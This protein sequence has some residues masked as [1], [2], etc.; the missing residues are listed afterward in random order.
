MFN[1]FVA[2][3]EEHKTGLI[4]SI[5][6]ALLYVFPIILAGQYYV[7]DMSRVINGGGWDHDGRFVATYLMQ[8][9]SFGSVI[10]SSFPY[11]TMISAVLLA[12]AGYSL[13][14]IFGIEEGKKIKISSL[15][16]ITSP[17][18]LE[19]LYY[20]YDSIIMALAVLLAI[21]PFYF[22]SK[23]RSFLIIS[24]ICLYLSF[25]L[26]QTAV[27]VYFAMMLLYILVCSTKNELNFKRLFNLSFLALVSF[28]IA[29]A[30]YKYSLSLLEIKEAARGKLMILESNFLDLF[31]DRVVIVYR[32]LV[33]DLWSTN[34]KYS[35]L[36][37][38]CVSIIGFIASFFV[39]RNI[40]FVLLALSVGLLIFVLIGMP[41]LVIKEPWWTARTFLVYP[42]L[43]YFIVIFHR[44]FR[45]QSLS[46][47]SIV[48]LVCFSFL[49]SAVAA[50]TEKNKDEYTKMV[51]SNIYSYLLKSEFE[52]IVI[53]GRMPIA[54]RNVIA[55]KEFPII[56]KISQT[57]ESQGWWWGVR[58]LSRYAHFSWPQNK[59]Q[60]IKNK[61]DFESVYSDKLLTLRDGGDVAIIDFNRGDCG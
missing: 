25:G 6:A 40:L 5:A 13:S 18:M 60:Y 61:C 26:F 44:F 20:R 35:I 2:F 36:L 55:H 21:L 4:F 46:R 28:F 34:Y 39:K 38:V 43:I 14:F 59:E 58:S 33:D 19:N 17:F 49:L 22:I 1:K 11:S 27:M 23:T 41:N 3:L 31:I 15:I 53:S 24:S 45:F 48:V 30:C 29:F 16:L 57:Y 37:L 10:F 32:T 47:V 50:T 52:Y 12:F 56:G 7:D 54:P 9:L 51:I 42:L 8:V